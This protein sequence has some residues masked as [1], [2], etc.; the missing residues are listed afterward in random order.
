[1][2]TTNLLDG[3]VLQELPTV[4][5]G[6]GLKK[7][8]MATSTRAG[9]NHDTLRA[10]YA[11]SSKPLGSTDDSFG[12]RLAKSVANVLDGPDD[13]L[14]RLAFER[15]PQRVNT[16]AAIYRPKLQG[17]P[18]SLLKR[19]AIQ[20]DLVAAVVHTR[21]NHIAQFGR[22]QSDRH[23]M[24]FKFVPYDGIME[25]LDEQGRNT[26]QERIRRAEKLLT[27]CG[28]TNGWSE[29]EKCSFSEFL[30]MQARNAVVVGRM[31]TEIIWTPDP[32]APGDGER[33]KFHSFRPS[34]AGTI[35]FAAP[36]HEVN[37]Q[38]RE[39]ALRMMETLKNEKLKKE[40]FENE[41]YAWVQ[42]FEGRP[43][44]AFGPQEMLVHFPYNIT[45]VEQMGYPV[46]PLDTALTAVT[47]HINITHHNRL[48]FQSGR[49]ARGM[50]IIKSPD[51]D[52]EIVAGV[53]QQF[54][55]SINSVQNAWRM[56]VF[57]LGPEDE[58]TWAPIDSAGGRDAEFQYLTDSNART[59]LA[60]FQMSPEE[61]PGYQHLSR[62]TNNQALSEGNTEYKLTAARDVGIRPIVASFEDF[63]NSSIVPLID[64][65]LSK[66]V[67]LKLLGLD[68]DTEE[69]ESVRI[70]QDSGVWM[71]MADILTKLEKK[72]LPKFTGS[73]IPLNPTFYQY[74]QS[75]MTFGEILEFWC[76]K[77]GASNAQLHPEFAFYQNPFFQQQ[78]QMLQQ[79]QAMQQQAAMGGQPG[80]PPPGGAPQGG[81]PAPAQDEEETQLSDQQR[82]GQAKGAQPDLASGLDQL[83]SVVAKS[84]LAK[85]EMAPNKKR[86]RELTIVANKN[87]MEAFVKGLADKVSSIANIA[88]AP[89]KK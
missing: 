48:Y 24:G 19:M 1:M 22:K 61:L 71:S 2:A 42:V 4:E 86:L 14:E 18:D 64:P 9:S 51:I 68:V 15:D 20:D 54:N 44:Q 81:A 76:G 43:M 50:L 21:S 36:Y 52:P 3:L 34:D 25:K 83:M 7:A 59:I 56:P 5:R 39:M 10:I 85:A 26:L 87:I 17:V 33:R 35:Y 30:Y 41:E 38:V 70:Q 6:S 69:K 77:Q 58:L 75:Y 46:T 29:Q 66:V 79:Q 37:Q 63:L 84:E 49:A 78:Q 16:Y 11:G 67:T 47:T 73:D 55:A 12:G 88:G 32:D 65:E 72:S 62:G 60:A 53:K 80:Q 28:Q 57:G 27:T 82:Q 31:A 8:Q 23:G 74:I 13:S 89:R 45:D 40:K